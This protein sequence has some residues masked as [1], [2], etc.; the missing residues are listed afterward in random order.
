MKNKYINL[1]GENCWVKTA[2]QNKTKILLCFLFIVSLFFINGCSKLKNSVDRK[3]IDFGLVITTS[4]AY[5]SEILWFDSNFDSIQEQKLPYAM[6]GTPFYSP[7][8]D[9]DKIYMIPEGLGNKKDT[10]KVISINKQSLDVEEYP[11]TNIALNHMASIGNN[12]YAINTLNGDSYLESYDVVSKKRNSVI[13][14]KVY[15]ETVIASSDKLFCFVRKLNYSDSEEAKTML[16]VYT[17]SLDLEAEIDLTEYGNPTSMYLEDEDNLYV[18]VNRNA[19]I[20][21]V[22]KILKINKSTFKISEFITKKD[23]PYNIFK[24]GDRFI[25]TYYDP[26]TNEGTEVSVWDENGNEQIFD[27][28]T[29]LTVA[30]VVNDKFVAANNNSIKIFSIPDFKLIKEHELSIGTSNYVSALLLMN[31]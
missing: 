7:V 30:G 2:I 17:P 31:E 8:S 23:I 27:L 29:P 9:A 5:K 1:I 4:Q 13:L 6:L 18:T 20:K 19:N 16:N 12:V 28:K 14:E 25:L 10:R 3:K 22:G 26:V 15:L 24:F 21:P 11:F